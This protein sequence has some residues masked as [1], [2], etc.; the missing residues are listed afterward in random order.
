MLMAEETNSGIKKSAVNMTLL[1]RSIQHIEGNPDCFR[2]GTDSCDRLDC[3]WRKYCLGRE[4][5]QPFSLGNS[6]ETS[7]KSQANE[8]PK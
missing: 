6:D 5:K 1:I 7:D 2:R 4:N 8:V 3:A